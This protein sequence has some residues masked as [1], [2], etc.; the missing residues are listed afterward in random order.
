MCLALT[1]R[2]VHSALIMMIVQN[3]SIAGNAL[4]AL[5][6]LIVAIQRYAPTVIVMIARI[7]KIALAVFLVILAKGMVALTAGYQRSVQNAKKQ[8]IRKQ[9]NAPNA[10]TVSLTSQM[11]NVQIVKEEDVTF[12]MKQGVVAPVKERN[13]ALS[14]RVLAIAEVLATTACLFV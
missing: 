9:I 8:D 5:T 11:V 4:Y 6:A 1:Q 13:I 12:A 10:Q 14:A 7:Q 3:V 2:D